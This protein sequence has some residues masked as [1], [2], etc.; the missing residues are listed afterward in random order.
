VLVTP[1]AD[2][3]GGAFN[4]GVLGLAFRDQPTSRTFSVFV[5]RPGGKAAKCAGTV[6][7]AGQSRSFCFGRTATNLEAQFF[8]GNLLYTVTMPS[9]TSGLSAADREVMVRIVTDLR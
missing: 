2:Y 8:T 4:R 3:V 6:V 5:G 1:S 7:D 9:P